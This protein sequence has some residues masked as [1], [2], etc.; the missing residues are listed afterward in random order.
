MYGTHLDTNDL[1]WKTLYLTFINRNTIRRKGCA[2]SRFIAATRQYP[3]NS[4]WRTMED[5]TKRPSGIPIK[6][7]PA[8]NKRKEENKKHPF[9]IS[10]PKL[11]S[12]SLEGK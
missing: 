9:I 3:S 10:S 12:E 1:L 11:S 8:T 5:D 4:C 2:Q 7:L 6:V